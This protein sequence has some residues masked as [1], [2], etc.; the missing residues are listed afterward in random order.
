MQNSWDSCPIAR[1]CPLLGSFRGNRCR[2]C[3]WCG[4]NTA[5]DRELVTS[6]LGR[7]HH[8]SSCRCYDPWAGGVEIYSGVSCKIYFL[9][10]PKVEP[11]G[12]DRYT[13]PLNSSSCSK[14]PVW[15]SCFPSLWR[16]KII[17]RKNVLLTQNCFPVSNFNMWFWELC[18][19]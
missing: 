18:Y 3:V 11:L 7:C 10:V 13:K 5:G 4:S 6:S 16:Q 9:V 15:H 8:Q 2:H 19:R 1:H 17:S 12:K 14:G